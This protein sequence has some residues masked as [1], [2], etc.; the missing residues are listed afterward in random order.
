L[1]EVYYAQWSC[2]KREEMFIVD[3]NGDLV[4]SF[5]VPPVGDNR[6]PDVLLSNGWSAFPGT[7]WAEAPPGQWSR[8]VHPSPQV[9]MWIHGGGQHYPAGGH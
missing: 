2:D 6:V 3:Q 1:T 7:E 4:T 9:R 5:P 8:A